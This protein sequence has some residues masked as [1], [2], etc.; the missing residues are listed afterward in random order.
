MCRLYH[1]AASGHT[2]LWRCQPPL[3][4][5][6]NI[7]NS[8]PV[9]DSILPAEQIDV[10]VLLC[11]TFSLLQLAMESMPG[12]AQQL[13]L[14]LAIVTQKDHGILLIHHQRLH[15]LQDVSSEPRVLGSSCMETYVSRF[16]M[17]RMC[18][19]LAYLSGMRMPRHVFKE[20]AI[21]YRH[22][23]HFELHE[24]GLRAVMWL[25]GQGS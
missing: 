18:H 25:G 10:G 6:A 3:A 23:L 21:A 13:F 15:R 8:F 5:S 1:V 20:P 4:V 16:F 14:L 22:H 24:N 11:V 17:H 7:R 2:G 19:V 9:C 12:C